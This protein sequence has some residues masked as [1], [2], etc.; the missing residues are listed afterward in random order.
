MGSYYY[1]MA[2]LPFLIYEQK[3]PMSSSAFKALVEP[4]LTESDVALMK[5][6]SIDPDP[7]SAGKEGPSYMESLPS[8]G[9]GFIDEWREWERSFRLNLSKHRA[10]KVRRDNVAV[11]EP[12]PYP[13]DAAAAA[14]RA[15]T[16]ESS[17]LEAEIQIDKARWNA[18][19]SFAG[20]DYFGINNIYAYFLKLLLLERRQAFN[21]ETGFSE[22]KSLYSEIIE[23]SQNS[24]HISLG[25]P[26]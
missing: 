10:V 24:G 9:C 4:L 22:Y 18:I 6:L 1:L 11:A 17:P 3:P 5:C 2:Q 21:V 14:A 26:K 12:S 13:Q 8:T 16:G 25:E 19:D 15:V 23:N 7:D 20:I